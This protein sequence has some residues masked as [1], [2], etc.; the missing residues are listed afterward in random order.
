MRH[1]CF[2]CSIMASLFLSRFRQQLNS[3]H[4][5]PKYSKDCIQPIKPMS[6]VICG[7]VAF[8]FINGVPGSMDFINGVCAPWIALSPYNLWG[9]WIA[10][11]E[12]PGRLCPPVILWTSCKHGFHVFH[13]NLSI[14]V[15]NEHNGIHGF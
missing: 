8:G 12:F 13:G 15:F 9:V 11:Y 14:Q 1:S 7:A 2:M 4:G 10:L 5:L 6:H 3:F